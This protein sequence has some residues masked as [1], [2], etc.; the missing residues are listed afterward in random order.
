M[1][2]ELRQYYFI[3][4]RPVGSNIWTFASMA[5]EQEA[6]NNKAIAICNERKTCTRIVSAMLPKQPDSGCF[7]A[8]LCDNDTQFVG[9]EGGAE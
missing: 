2:E 6:A 8:L 5:C 3:V 4:E 1:S 7:Y 9:V